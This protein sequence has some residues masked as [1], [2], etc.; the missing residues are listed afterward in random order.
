VICPRCSNPVPMRS[1]WQA[2]GL[3]GV[4][5]PICNASLWPTYLRSAVVLAV[6]LLA[7]NF[8]ATVLRRAGYDL[9]VV[10]LGCAAALF[11]VYATLAPF[12]L[13]LRLKEDPALLLHTKR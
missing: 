3:S 9:A 11:V 5:C 6:A 4:V 1:L 7:A 13:R 10:M 2:T 12:V 8:E